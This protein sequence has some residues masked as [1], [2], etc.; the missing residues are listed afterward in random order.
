MGS[1][2]SQNLVCSSVD[3][4]AAAAPTTPS[5]RCCCC[6][7]WPKTTSFG[8]SNY[9]ILNEFKPGTSA[10]SS[11]TVW[12]KRSDRGLRAGQDT[13]SYRVH[14]C[15]AAPPLFRFRLKNSR[16]QTQKVYVLKKWRSYTSDDA[17][18]TKTQ[19]QGQPQN[20]LR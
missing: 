9:I 17:P 13:Q 11:P 18:P 8:K 20:N 16:G 3:A 14:V 2:R 19:L 6:C 4:A 15:I 10:L 7:C 12:G 5:F 1:P